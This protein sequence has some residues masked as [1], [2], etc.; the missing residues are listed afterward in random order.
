M[1]IFKSMANAMKMN[2][3]QKLITP[4]TGYSSKSF[5][6]VVV[7]ILGIGLLVMPIIILSI[8]I[9]TNHTIQTDL[10]GLAAYIGSIS[11]LFAS[12]GFTKAFSEK[13]EHRLPGPDGVIGTADDIIVKMT[14]DEYAKYMMEIEKKKVG[15]DTPEEIPETPTDEAQYV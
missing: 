5:L 10:T 4:N 11:T 7:T 12:A 2:W 9:W 1:N 14:D 3:F 6:L 8:E 15:I 13:H